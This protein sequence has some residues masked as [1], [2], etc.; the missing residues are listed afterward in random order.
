MVVVLGRWL[1]FDLV[2]CFFSL[3]CT[4]GVPCCLSALIMHLERFQELLIMYNTQLQIIQA[5]KKL[6]EN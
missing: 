5:L 6:Q 4:G 1:D 2:S 3:I